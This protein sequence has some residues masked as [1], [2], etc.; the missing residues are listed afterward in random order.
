M[1]FFLRPNLFASCN[2]TF[3][4]WWEVLRLLHYVFIKEQ[5]AYASA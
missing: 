5:G 3:S 2:N 1:S 4:K